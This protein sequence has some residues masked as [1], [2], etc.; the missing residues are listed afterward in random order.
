MLHVH[1]FPL[2]ELAHVSVTRPTVR[3]GTASGDAST[4][5]VGIPPTGMFLTVSFPANSAAARGL[6]VRRG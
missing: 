2:G 5:P 1:L 3:L 4:T 6:S